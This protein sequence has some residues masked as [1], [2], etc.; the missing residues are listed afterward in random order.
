MEMEGMNYMTVRHVNF[1]HFV[2]VALTK[3]CEV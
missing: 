1:I 3:F 2:L